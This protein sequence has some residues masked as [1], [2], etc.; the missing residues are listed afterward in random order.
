MTEK[1]LI[2]LWNDKRSQLTR[3]QLHSVIALAVLTFLT[4]TGDLV[5]A[6]TAEKLFAAAFLVTVGAL[7][8]LTQFAIIREAHGIVAEL[9]KLSNP[10]PIASSIAKSGRYLSMTMTLMVL[11]SVGLLGSFALVVL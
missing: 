2:Q 7:G 4:I 5:A 9:S 1:D 3:A 8:N 11:F 6:S 10:G